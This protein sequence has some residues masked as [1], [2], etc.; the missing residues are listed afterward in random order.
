MKISLPPDKH[1]RR[2]LRF[3]TSAGHE[4]HRARRCVFLDIAALRLTPG[5]CTVEG[6][7]KLVMRSIDDVACDVML[8]VRSIMISAIRLIS[9]MGA[10][11][12]ITLG[13]EV[14]RTISLQIDY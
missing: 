6:E 12:A 2:L 10:R 14:G 1:R 8:P 13:Q 9:A 7:D 5:A 11:R 4:S 3:I